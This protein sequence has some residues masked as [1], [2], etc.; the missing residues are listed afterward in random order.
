M[1]TRKQQPGYVLA[2]GPDV[3]LARED[4]RDSAG[5][6]ITGEYVEQAVADVHAR[7]GRGRPALAGAE[8]RSPQVTFRLPAQLRARAQEQ[9]RREGTPIS[10]VARKALE[11]Y[12]AR[13]SRAS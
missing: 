2:P 6:R 1:A 12:L 4:I 10:A 11:E 5:R 9:A 13:N 3:D 8:T 7:T